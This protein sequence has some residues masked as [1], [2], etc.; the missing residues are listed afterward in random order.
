MMD[1][2]RQKHVGMLRVIL[3]YKYLRSKSVHVVVFVNTDLI[4]NLFNT[5]LVAQATWDYC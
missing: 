2:G 1:P 3:K 4:Y 5:L